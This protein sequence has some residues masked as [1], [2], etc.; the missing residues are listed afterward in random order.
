MKGLGS[1]KF[2]III[3][4]DSFSHVG[5]YCLEFEK[6]DINMLEFLQRRP[7]HALEL[8]EI[9]PVVHQLATAL[10]FLQDVGIVHAD[11]KPE[12]IMIVDRGQQPMRVKIIDFGLALKNPE[13]HTGTVLQT[14]WYRCPEVLLGTAFNGAIDVWS[15]GCITVEIFTGSALFPGEDEEDMIRMSILRRGGQ[16]TKKL[17]DQAKLSPAKREREDI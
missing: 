1:D 9:R 3:F 8:K 10:D 5:Y 17:R 11:L 7:D 12:N 14:L 4:N 2:N 15:L 13:E 16:M 6:L